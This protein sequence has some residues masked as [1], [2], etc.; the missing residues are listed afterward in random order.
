MAKKSEAQKL[1]TKEK[2]K[3]RAKER[4]AKLKLIKEREE[5]SN[6]TWPWQHRTEKPNVWPNWQCC[7]TNSIKTRPV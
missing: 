2:A 6:P 3:A 7:S 4:R 1:A 5:A